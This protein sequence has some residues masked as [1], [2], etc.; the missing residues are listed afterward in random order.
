MK[1]LLS[2]ALMLCLTTSL[3]AQTVSVVRYPLATR[4]ETAVSPREIGRAIGDDELK[5]IRHQRIA[6]GIMALLG[7]VILFYPPKNN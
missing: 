6:F 1:M 5:V 4:T 2:I 3:R 7:L